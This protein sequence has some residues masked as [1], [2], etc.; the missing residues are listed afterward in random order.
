M[1]RRFLVITALVAMC[2]VSIGQN[3][4][5]IEILGPVASGETPHLRVT[6]GAS[7]AAISP[8][9]QFALVF[10][11]TPMR[12]VHVYAPGKH[13]YQIVNV[14]VAS[15]SWLQ[16]KPTSYPPSTIYHFKP[17]DERV[18]VYSKPFRLVRDLAILSTPAAL[19]A[20]AGRTSVLL[21]A[22]LEY[23][24]CDDTICYMPQKVPLSWTLAL[25]PSDGQ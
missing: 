17:L 12:N 15:R 22:T 23:Q 1:T 20:L 3:Q 2:D 13:T 18:A 5:P 16:V 10:D 4:K 25:K 11:V 8:G 7:V 9:M 6:A 21:D 14:D 19:K 24:A